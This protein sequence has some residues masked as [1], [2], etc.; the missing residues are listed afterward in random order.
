MLCSYNAKC[1]PVYVPKNLSMPPGREISRQ[2][3]EI[4]HPWV[5]CS[6]LLSNRILSSYLLQ[7]VG[8]H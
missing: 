6:Y 1:R 7:G 5:A 4:F 2:A 3:G 8:V